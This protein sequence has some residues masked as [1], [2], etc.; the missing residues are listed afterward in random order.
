MDIQTYFRTNTA[1]F[2]RYTFAT[3]VS[4]WV[5]LALQPC[6][7]AMEMA[8]QSESAPTMMMD[9]DH[10]CDH[11][12]EETDTAECQ[13][14]DWNTPNQNLS[15]HHDI[16]PL[17]LFDSVVLVLSMSDFK[18]SDQLH[19]HFGEPPNFAI[20]PAPPAKQDVLNC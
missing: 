16:K 15:P 6:A 10:P 18:P 9:M 11:C 5:M 12:P 1:L 2:A 20:H 8:S 19:Q 14:D 17:A 3:F 7:M 13:F 4:V